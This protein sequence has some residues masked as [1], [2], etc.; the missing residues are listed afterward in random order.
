M[1]VRPTLRLS[2]VAV[3]HNPNVRLL[4][5]LAMRL[6]LFCSLWKMIDTCPEFPPPHLLPGM[7]N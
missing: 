4:A 6:N 3:N 5:R 2:H 7:E 1:R